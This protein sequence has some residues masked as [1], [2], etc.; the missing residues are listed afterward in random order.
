M[1][2]HVAPV[3]WKTALDS[4]TSPSKL[5]TAPTLRYR[6]HHK[7]LAQLQQPGLNYCRGIYN[8]YMHQ[9]N[10]AL[11]HL[12]RARR[13][14]E[15]GVPAMYAMVEICLNPEDQTVGGESMAR[16]LVD[17]CFVIA[18]TVLATQTQLPSPWELRQ[19]RSF[20]VKSRRR[21]K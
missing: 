10:E 21:I 7:Y 20:W 12:N 6:R 1:E 3:N 14:T 16:C 2:Y 15:W 18:D 17:A 19:P 5:L 11:K 4:S 9:P 13:D 8:R